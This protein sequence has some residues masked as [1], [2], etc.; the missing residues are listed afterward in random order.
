MRPLISSWTGMV[1]STDRFIFL[2]DVH[3]FILKFG[4]LLVHL[5]SNVAHV[6][7][8]LSKEVTCSFRWMNITL[9]TDVLHAFALEPLRDRF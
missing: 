8:L 1:K 3:D 4:D 7:A 2:A 6:S 9:E 5:S